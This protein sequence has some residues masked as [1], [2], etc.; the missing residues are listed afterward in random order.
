[1]DDEGK[2]TINPIKAKGTFTVYNSGYDDA[3]KHDEIVD[4]MLKGK[5][6]AGLWM[7]LDNPY[8]LDRII[9]AFK[10]VE[11][12]KAIKALVKLT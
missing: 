9:D 3:E 11:S 12:K 6:S 10:A 5:L 4:L 7:D 1:L 2:V 8:P